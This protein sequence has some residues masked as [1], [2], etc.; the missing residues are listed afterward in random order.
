MCR[1]LLTQFSGGEAALVTTDLA[2]G[3]SATAVLHRQIFSGHCVRRLSGGPQ[4][5][6]AAPG[7]VGPEVLFTVSNDCTAFEAKAISVSVTPSTDIRISTDTCTNHPIAPLGTCAVGLQLAPPKDA[8]P[9]SVAA[10]LTV[11]TDVGLGLLTVTG[12]VGGTLAF[13]AAPTSI[14]FGA[15]PVAQASTP[16]TVT[17]TSLGGVAL[18]PLTVSFS[19]AGLEQLTL[20]ATTCNGGL[21]PGASCQITVQYLPV[22]TAGVAAVMTVTDGSLTVAIPIAGSGV[23]I[24]Q[25]A[26]VDT[27]QG[28]DGQASPG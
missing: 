11:S 21:S 27:T 28:V 10:V 15:I 16:Q 13:A 14:N 8:A 7:A 6:F 25:D 2:S 24:V 1:L 26:S 23:S 3:Q 17:I 4:L 19:G 18:G 22:D 20:L 9:H 5:G 12:N